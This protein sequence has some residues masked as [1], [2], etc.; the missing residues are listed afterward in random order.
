MKVPI[1]VIGQ[2][3]FPRVSRNKDV[4]FVKIA[5][6]LVFVFFAIIYTAIFLFSG[7]IVLLF[8]GTENIVAASL[9]RLLAT[10]IL[11]VCLGLFFAE[12][13]LVPFGKLRDYTK[14]R[15]FS[16]FI[17]ITMIG[18]L[19]YFKQIGLYQMASVIIV[20]ESFVLIYSFYLCKKNKII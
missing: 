15:T 14:M 13:L 4:R 5:M 20:V 17:Y 12:L 18:I 6:G 11:P 1:G 16:L 7:K 9:L 8:T 10:S 2:T 19:T 3:L